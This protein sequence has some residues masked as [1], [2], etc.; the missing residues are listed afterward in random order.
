V[1]VLARGWQ[2]LTCRHPPTLVG[3]DIGADAV[4]LLQ[5]A[6]KGEGLYVSHY[7]SEPLPVGAV[8]ER[9]IA[10]IDAVGVAI[11]RAHKRSGTKAR[12]AAVALAAPAV[13]LRVVSVPA[14]L[15]ELELEAQLELEAARVLPTD[16]G[17][18]YLDFEVLGAFPDDPTR[19]QILLVV[20]H[21]GPVRQC[22]TALKLGG[23]QARVIDVESLAMARA[24]IVLT[25]QSLP[26]E[27]IIEQT[28]VLPDLVNPLAGCVLAPVISS[29]VKDASVLMLACG[30]ALRGVSA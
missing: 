14:G 17:P 16:S 15:N 12:H 5:F 23:L 7:A 24:R 27:Q 4:R 29:H 10:D 1:N 30:L 13:V 28:V 19:L 22:M 6:R 9:Q 2:R 3:L 25:G 26:L 18:Q 20:A 21:A 8:V 11:A